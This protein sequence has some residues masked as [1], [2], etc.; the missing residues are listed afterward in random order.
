MPEVEKT[1]SR[2]HENAVA[3]GGVA[4]HQATLRIAQRAR[5]EEDLVRHAE[6]PDVMQAAGA[7]DRTGALLR[8]AECARRDSR[9]PADLL[10]VASGAGVDEL[11]RTKQGLERLLA[12]PA[13]TA[14]SDEPRRLARPHAHESLAAPMASR[15]VRA[16]S[17]G[18]KGFGRNAG[19]GRGASRMAS[20]G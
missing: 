8:E 17:G 2:V 13:G 14:L 15:M 11:G 10:Q 18:V 3:D 16:R 20:S 5:F 1:R 9:V 19:A 6:L 4:L 12:A 7:R